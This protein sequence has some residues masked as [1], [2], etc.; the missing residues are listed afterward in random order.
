MTD[1]P[2]YVSFRDYLRVIRRRWL[3]IASIVVLCGAATYVVSKG[4]SKTYQAEASL[5]YLGVNSYRGDVGLLIPETETPDQ[6]AA[7]AAQ[8]IT[9]RTV[10]AA[11]AAHIGGNPPKTPA[12]LIKHITVQPEAR[13]SLVVITAVSSDP[14]FA[15]QVANAFAVAG[16]DTETA[17]VR[18]SLSNRAN[19]LR[20]TLGG[21]PR[22]ATTAFARSTALDQIQ[23]LNALSKIAQPVVIIHSAGIPNTPLSPKVGRNTVVGALLGLTLG[24]LIAFVRDALDRRFRNAG[25]IGT[26]LSLPVIGHVA[27]KQLG[28]SM[29]ERKRGRRSSPATLEPFRIIR[30]NIEF[31]DVAKPPAMALVTSALAEEGK[32]TVAA[33]VAM[34]HAATGKRTLLLECDLRRPTLAKRLGL[35]STPG[36]ADHLLGKAGRDELFQMV[37]LDELWES[38]SRNG[39]TPKVAVAELTCVTAGTP[40]AQSTELL[41]SPAFHELLR[42]VRTAYDAVIIDSAPLLPV[43]DTLPLIASADAIVVCVRTTRTT[44]DQVAAAKAVLTRFPA[45]P[46]AIVLTGLRR[47]SEADYGYYGHQYAPAKM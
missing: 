38:P 4:A 2:R 21:V 3:L 47:G 1:S 45:R 6:R 11:A 37:A 18:S 9:Q 14:K 25:E 32:S 8:T 35:K 43:A 16:R 41:T 17:N 24:L 7:I 20:Q 22:N 46:T 10:A 23:R 13:T 34:S 5:N 42:E 15:A 44:T 12:Y 30:T 39:A 31:L 27:D 29:L 19:V 33:G 28:R 36:L 26:Q 40:V